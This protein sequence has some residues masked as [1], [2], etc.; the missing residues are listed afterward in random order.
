VTD[1]DG[2]HY[3]VSCKDAEQAL[4]DQHVTFHLYTEDPTS[5]VLTKLEGHEV[6]DDATL[7]KKKEG[8]VIWPVNSE[9][10][11]EVKVADHLYLMEEGKP[12]A[13]G[14]S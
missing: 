2:G 6:R 14:A 9:G 8:K 5:Y 7:R 10:L 3:T 4:N 11:L 12:K 13:T 1:P